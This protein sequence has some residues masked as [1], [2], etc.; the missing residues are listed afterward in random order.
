[1]KMVYKMILVFSVVALLA[2]F[3]CIINCSC[4]LMAYPVPKRTLMLDNTKVEEPKELTLLVY[5]AADNDLESYAIRNLK[6]MERADFSRMNVLVLF[7]RSESYDETNEN[8]T[9]TRLFEITHDNS[10]GSSI[11]SKRINCP[12]LGLSDNTETELD[13][14]NY[15][16]L[17]TFIEFAKSSYTAN[18]YALIMWGHGTG[19]RFSS[20]SSRAVA[21]DDKSHSYMCVQELGLALKDE[22]L[23]VIGFDTCFGSAFENLYELKDCTD[24]IVASPG[25]TP[26]AGWDYKTLLQE[27]SNTSFSAQEIAAIMEYAS[28]QNNIIT[29]A[30]EL[31]DLMLV[32][33]D[34]SKALA[35]TITDEQSRRTVLDLLIN[36][37]SY[38][39]TQYPSDL[40]IDVFSMAQVFSNSA[41]YQL[42]ACARI[43]AQKT[44]NIQTGLYLIPKTGEGVL[45]TAHSF[46]YIKND[47]NQTQ[48]AFIKNSSW[49]VPT[50]TG[51]SGSLLDKL[52]YWNF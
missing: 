41:N 49:W 14:G 51:N 47:A 36:A 42:Q 21:I 7:D 45:A 50:K 37:K 26:A 17:K 43:L 4:N 20:C 35:Q 18:S 23:S 3:E 27:L 22:S 44:S 40:F 30:S 6:A 48:C 13:M 32:I 15:T 28:A 5:M 8:W 33:E 1:M 34:F 46:D 29:K 9:D 10:N 31:Q 16:V 25:L 52:F 19:W 2:G 24:Y 38:C 12:P 11:V 39:Y